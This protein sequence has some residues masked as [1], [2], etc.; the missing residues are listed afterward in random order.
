[1]EGMDEGNATKGTN[2][3]DVLSRANRIQALNSIDQVS[4]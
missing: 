2:S 3:A 4:L 1:M